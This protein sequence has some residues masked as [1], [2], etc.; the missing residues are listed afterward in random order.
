MGIREDYEVVSER[1]KIEFRDVEHIAETIREIENFSFE[2]Q[3]DYEE[4]VFKKLKE[5]LDQELRKVDD[6]LREK[7]KD[8][9]EEI[10]KKY[11]FI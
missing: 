10:L 2:K 3:T 6:E 5:D 4:K 1:Y 11:K 7:V 8:E 9:L